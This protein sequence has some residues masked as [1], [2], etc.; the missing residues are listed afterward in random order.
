MS[1]K[2]KISKYSEGE[3]KKIFVI[4]WIIQDEKN[5]NQNDRDQMWMKN[6]LQEFI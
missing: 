3:I 6:K 4:S 1:I 2:F 5:N